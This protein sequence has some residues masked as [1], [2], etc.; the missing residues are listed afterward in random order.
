MINKLEDLVDEGVLTSEEFT[1]W[2]DPD[3]YKEI[4]KIV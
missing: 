1:E 2:V 4:A 3:L